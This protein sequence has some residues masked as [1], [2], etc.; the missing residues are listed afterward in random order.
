V[1]LYPYLLEADLRMSESPSEAM[2]ASLM[3]AILK[4]MGLI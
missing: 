4:G 1:R 3:L 2:G